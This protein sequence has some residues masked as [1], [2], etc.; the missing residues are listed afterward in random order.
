MLFTGTPMICS[1]R[2]QAHLP[3]DLINI[4]VGKSAASA[5]K[6]LL[7]SMHTT[8]QPAYAAEHPSQVSLHS[9]PTD[10]SARQ[11]HTT[12]KKGYNTETSAT[13]TTA[14]RWPQESAQ[15][16]IPDQHKSV[17]TERAH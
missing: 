2:T 7:A 16:A 8:H 13:T 6:W 17:P 1:R 3:Q 15:E 4:C 14:G 10:N 9:L 5:T 12:T 11:S